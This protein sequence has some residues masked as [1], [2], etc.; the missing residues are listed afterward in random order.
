MNY[1][2]D[3]NIHTCIEKYFANEQYDDVINI[4]DD[5]RKVIKDL[6]L[7][8]YS[9]FSTI[10]KRNYLYSLMITK[11]LNEYKL[12]YQPF[13]DESITD[14]TNTIKNNVPTDEMSEI[15]KG[16]VRTKIYYDHTII[17]WGKYNGMSISRVKSIDPQYLDFCIRH[18]V[19]FCV[20]FDIL[21]DLSYYCYDTIVYNF[22]KHDFLKE[23]QRI[24]LEYKKP[25]YEK[26]KYYSNSQSYSNIYDNPHYNDDLD[27]DQ[28]SLEFWDSI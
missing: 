24:D 20:S 15:T 10:E 13:I 22:V 1:S 9:F 6:N 16:T 5:V 4:V 3:N 11:G 7:K 8:E 28:Q 21:F 17:R 19:H 2:L 18:I 27:M 14:Y 23:K 12:I 26:N 25:P